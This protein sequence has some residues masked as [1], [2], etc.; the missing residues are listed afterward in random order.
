MRSTTE[1]LELDMSLRQSRTNYVTLALIF[2]PIAVIG[3]IYAF[4]AI[5]AILRSLL[6]EHYP[7]GIVGALFAI[8]IGVALVGVEYA[9]VSQSIEASRRLEILRDHPD[10]TVQR[11][12]APFQS[13]MFG[14]YH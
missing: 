8:L 4:V 9:I 11:L 1:T 5:V 2:L 6:S 7:I 13:S 14:P 10:Q 12:P 3:L